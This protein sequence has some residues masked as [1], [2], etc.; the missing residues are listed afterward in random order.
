MFVYF[1]EKPSYLS[2]SKLTNTSSRLSQH[3]YFDPENYRE[4]H[5]VKSLGDLASNLQDL[6]LQFKQKENKNVSFDNISPS[7]KHSET[8]HTDAE[9]ARLRNSDLSFSGK[10]LSDDDSQWFRRR[11]Q[12]HKGS[13]AHSSLDFEK[14]PHTA[15]YLT[16]TGEEELYTPEER[17]IFPLSISDSLCLSYFPVTMSAPY[18]LSYIDANPDS[19]SKNHSIRPKSAAMVKSAYKMKERNGVDREYF[20][21]SEAPTIGN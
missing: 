17:G 14:R 4:R 11:S 7:K 1:R 6:S 20:M 18:E 16:S 21:T 5:Y 15:R 9:L 3:T 2:N 10:Y 8:F 13:Y 12:H 19:S